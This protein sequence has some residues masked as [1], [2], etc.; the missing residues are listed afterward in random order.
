MSFQFR[1][2]KKL[3]KLMEVYNIPTIAEVVLK[4]EEELTGRKPEEVR[5]NMAKRLQIMK[6]SAILGKENPKKSK[7]GLVGGDA[8]KIEE[9]DASQLFLSEVMRKA[10]EYSIGVMESNARMGKIV[11]APTA[12]SSGILPGAVLAVQECWNLSEEKA[13]DGLL[14]AAGIGIVIANIGTFSAA[15][16]GC[17]AEVGASSAMAAA[18]VSAMRGMSAERCINAA[19]L[20][21][22]NLLGLACDPIGGLVEVPCVKRNGMGVVH[23]LT[24]SDMSFAGITSHIPF[25]EVVEAMTNIASHMGEALRE[26]AKGGLAV[27]PTAKRITCQS[28]P[29]S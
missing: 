23:A 10:V 17:Q 14:T 1:S 22:K 27:T 3:A 9:V 15:A 7:S 24:A 26:T 20:A 13:V 19:A 12:G 18:A 16:A 29:H 5:A 4:G 8:K 21:L 11:A 28:C 25:D 6:Q 2:S